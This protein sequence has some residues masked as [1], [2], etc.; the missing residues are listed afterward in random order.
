MRSRPV[1]AAAAALATAAATAAAVVALAGPS[2]AV[3]SGP[4]WEPDPAS[5]GTLTFHDATGAV[6]TSGSTA[7]APFAAYAV[8]SA[9]LRAGDTKAG[10]QFANPDPGTNT[11]GWYREGVGTYETNPLTSA[12]AAVASASGPAY[13]GTASDETLDH[14]EADSIIST[15]AGYQNVVQVRL[16]TADANGN[17]TDT[18]D[19]ADLSIDPATHRW[20]QIYPGHVT[21]PAA[22]TSLSAHV[23]AHT[24]T[25]S[26]K[27][28]TSTGGAPVTS[29]TVQAIANGN[30]WYTV[31]TGV[32]TLSRA[33]GVAFGYTYQFR[34]AAVNAAGTG[35]FSAAS[36]A[37]R[38]A[39]DGT[40]L[41]GASVT[42]HSVSYGGR[43]TSSIHLIDTTTG[44][45]VLPGRGVGLYYRYSTTGAW[46]YLGA[47]T[48]ASNGVAGKVLTPSRAIELQWR[49][50]GDSYHRASTGAVTSTAVVQ[51]FNAISHPTTITHGHQGHVYG[52]ISPAQSGHHVY[53]Q[54]LSGSSWR[55][56]SSVT[57]KNQTMPSHHV[58]VGY[59]FS[60]TYGTKGTHTY[61]LYVSAGNGLSAAYSPSFSVKVT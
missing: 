8:G 30:A 23:S 21:A 9:T 1:R 33:I 7:T 53:L 10:L 14:F 6:I 27:A 39:A 37:V 26:W 16:R 13:A 46:T 32:K 40:A 58:A 50:A 35:A 34:V 47:V 17:P 11:Y 57:T 60:P 29:Y 28:P 42:S 48:T 52:V 44:G 3:T 12:P 36:P 56:I 5:V 4:P 22:P 61:R 24:A 15:S 43:I 25:I 19:V 45:S 18:Y 41:I 51:K 20:T 2:A 49:Y 38:L 31:A 54:M 59:A 55:T